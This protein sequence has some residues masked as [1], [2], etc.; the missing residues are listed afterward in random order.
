MKTIFNITDDFLTIMR[1]ADEMDG[2]ITPD[3]ETALELN[4]NN[5][6][7][8]ATN[9]VGY[10]K[11]IE[12]DIDAID[13]EI[14][15]LTALKKAKQNRVEW[16]RGTLANA[17]DVI[18]GGKFETSIFKLSIRRNKSVDVVNENMVPAVFMNEKITRTPNKT[19]IK[20]AIE[21]GVP[22]DG[23]QI[24]ESVSLQIK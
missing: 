19:A 20:S 22:V 12:S 8:K 13:A 1:M 2:E 11:T 6:S 15:R 9:Y 24:V 5:L 17:I 14:K 21:S 10:I 18:C 23:C 7:Q 3:I 16:M 4:Q